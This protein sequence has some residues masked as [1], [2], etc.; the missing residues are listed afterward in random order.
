MTS[1]IVGSLILLT[2]SLGVAAEGRTAASSAAVSNVADGLRELAREGQWKELA[3]KAK[4]VGDRLIRDAVRDPK[5]FAETATYRAL[6]HLQMG[7]SRDALW[8]WQAALNFAPDV[9][10]REI[11]HFPEAAAVLS[12]SALPSPIQ[13]KRDPSI[14]PARPTYTVQPASLERTRTGR[15]PIAFGVQLVVGIDGVPYDPRVIGDVANEWDRVYDALDSL[16]QWR[17][18]PAST[19][20]GPVEFPTVVNLKLGFGRTPGQKGRPL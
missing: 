5:P 15:K 8:H 11:E 4:T 7:E 14:R 1:R 9:A 19:S 3:R 13:P 12:K 2:L 10:I 17:F 20:A 16:R 6:A 18:S